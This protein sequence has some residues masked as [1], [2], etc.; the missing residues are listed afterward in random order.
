MEVDYCCNS[1]SWS[2]YSSGT[3]SFSRPGSPTAT[4]RPLVFAEEARQHWAV[5]YDMCEHVASSIIM[6]F[7][8]DGSSKKYGCMRRYSWTRSS[9]NS[10]PE[11]L[12]V[13][14]GVARICWEIWSFILRKKIVCCV[15]RTELI[16]GRD[17]CLND[18]SVAKQG[19]YARWVGEEAENPQ[20][21]PRVSILPW[22][23]PLA[24]SLV[25]TPR[26][27]PT[28]KFCLRVCGEGDATHRLGESGGTWL[29]FVLSTDVPYLSKETT[30][31]GPVSMLEP[32]ERAWTW[33]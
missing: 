12:E 24:N 1:G 25:L 14:A 32:I 16:F 6:G 2:K 13:P 27:F 22:D 18:R 31:N 20:N 10:K 30:S 15:L 5:M 21:T 28:L 19:V 11:P 26:D 33:R 7:E 9:R 17:H 4:L 8:C 29:Q 3:K 23:H